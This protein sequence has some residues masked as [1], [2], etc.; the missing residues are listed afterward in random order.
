[1][2]GRI[3]GP[4]IAPPPRPVA[5]PV[6][7][8]NPQTGNNPRG[9]A[10][11][12]LPQVAPRTVTTG[13]NPRGM[14]IDLPIRPP[15]VNDQQAINPDPASVV[16]VF[17]SQ[18]KAQ[19]QAIVAGAMKN[20]GLPTSKIVLNYARQAGG[21]GVPVASVFGPRPTLA[22]VEQ[23]FHGVAAV[24]GKMFV[25]AARDAVSLPAETLPTVAAIGSHVVSAGGDLVTG[26][27]G[28]AAQQEKQAAGGIVDP[29][30]QLAEHPVRTFVDHPLLTPLMLEPLHG[31]ARV[32]AAP[33][34]AFAP[35]SALGRVVST[36][37]PGI[38]LTGKLTHERPAYNLSPT[39]KPG[40]VALE[41]MLY[42]HAPTGELIPREGGT[43]SFL[44]NRQIN[45]EIGQLVGTRERI[46]VVNREEARGARE[47]AVTPS[48]PRRAASAAKRT[49]AYGSKRAAIPGADVL[50]RIADAAI[51]RPDTVEEDL[52]THLAQVSANRPNLL[53]DPK[54]LKAHDEYVKQTNRALNNK[55]FLRNPVPA[56]KAAAAYAKDYA[57]VEAEAARLGHFGRITSDALQRRTL[58]HYAVTHMGAS[59]DDVKGLV[60]TNGDPL[61]NGQI[62]S[63]LKSSDGTGGR[64]PAYTPDRV[65]FDSEGDARRANFVSSERRPLPSTKKNTLYAYTHGLTEPGHA[66]LTEQHVLMRGIV[67]SHHSQNAYLDALPTQKPGGGYWDTFEG[68]KR[69]APP[70]YRP[71]NVAQPFHSQESLDQ[72][73]Q[74]AAPAT[75]EEE[76][77]R[78][79]LDLSS[80][81]QPGA[82]GR[83]AI[84]DDR[85]LAALR[86]HENQI[87][88]NALLRTI[89]GLNNQFR[90]VALATSAKHIPGVAQEDLIRDIAGG[91]G[92]RSWVTGRRLLSTAEQLRP[93]AGK[94]LRTSLTGGQLAGMTQAAKTYTVADH[95]AGT[96]AYPFLKAMEATFKAPG[97]RQLRTTWRA[98]TK[99]AIGSTK[100]LL[101]QQ[102]QIAGLGK[103]ALREHGYAEAARTAGFMG[104]V[105]RAFGLHG[106]MLDD[107][108][109]GLFDPAKARQMR[110]TINQL[111]GK[112]TGLSPSAQTALMFSPFG[113]WWANSVRFLARMPID[114][115]VKTGLLAAATVGTQQQRQQQGL[116]M[117][118]PNA[119]PPY[120]QGGIPAGGKI[121]A[122][123][124]YS[125]FGIANDPLE[126]AEGLLQPWL[127]PA[128]TAALGVDWLG[129]PLTSP[130][131]NT[132]RYNEKT[133][134][135]GQRLQYIIDSV[136]ASFV[137]L[138]SKAEQVATG[139]ATQ[140]DVTP[141][142]ILP[143]LVRGKAPATETPGN[144]PLAGLKKAM[145]PFREYTAAQGGSSIGGGLGDIVLPGSGDLSGVVL[146]GASTGSLKDVVIP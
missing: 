12:A 38:A 101:E 48:L 79:S 78:R 103:A 83:W 16:K 26:N 8:A 9:T 93:E 5:K 109:R 140:L 111:Y 54:A 11:T 6:P 57:P 31:V 142:G 99:F 4:A 52:R 137:P 2:L 98:W 132:D 86:Q 135:T 119:L 87:Q 124:Y 113:L 37:R 128:V 73:L 1:M 118:A 85:A 94:E 44:R 69:D 84:V 60:D 34:R 120:E 74:D 51:R 89:R 130:G 146:P 45:Q 20:P 30:I 139:G 145:F 123:N 46:R 61:S 21:Y 43:G 13:A 36:D 53:D 95:W 144:G 129:K 67:D 82:K 134:N 32:M 33:I 17:E 107:A 7:V 49:L 136:L 10:I 90:T 77:V 127:T 97:L 91:V 62:L 121:L 80:R 64:L 63:H 138:Y 35:E 133:P 75:I 15:T 76:A 27:F 112:W 122:Q 116:D 40:Q 39:V 23:P 19:Q 71:I 143:P 92:F 55:A 56:F 65:R 25:N 117:F 105:H 115:P 22:Q 70:G 72:A 100:H 42:K 28:G 96:N 50:A 41:K 18:P 68:A 108:A 106:Q 104:L 126:T 131:Q 3:G 141:S 14:T 88:P 58:M 81:L 47:D 24:I 114:Q 125:P 102:H 110:A 66:A 59:M 29:Y